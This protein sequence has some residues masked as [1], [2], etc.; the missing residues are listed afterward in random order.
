MKRKLSILT[1][2][3]IL[4]LPLFLSAYKVEAYNEEIGENNEIVSNS[5]A[6]ENT[7]P[8]ETVTALADNDDNSTN[9]EEDTQSNEDWTDFSNAKFELKKGGLLSDAFIEISGV[10]PKEKHSYYIYITSNSNKP[11]VFDANGWAIINGRLTLTYD[12][13]SKTLNGRINK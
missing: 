8:S 6:E 9:G 7:S 13:T 3:L 10:T 12:K 5:T 2:I 1:I 11:D 4:I